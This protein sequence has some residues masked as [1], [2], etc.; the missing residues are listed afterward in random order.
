MP[1]QTHTNSQQLTT[2]KHSHVNTLIQLRAIRREI[3]DTSHHIVRLLNTTINIIHPI[4]IIQTINI[5]QSTHLKKIIRPIRPIVHTLF[6]PLPN[7]NFNSFS[8][9][10]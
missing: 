7:S 2:V 10:N 6:I 1:R 3:T 8:I 9:I 4:G 5:L